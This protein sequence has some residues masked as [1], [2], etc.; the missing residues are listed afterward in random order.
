MAEVSRRAV[1]R[2]VV[3]PSSPV[4][5][6]HVLTENRQSERYA[7]RLEFLSKLCEPPIS[8]QLPFRGEGV[9]PPVAKPSR[10]F[11]PATT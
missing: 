4:V 11:A 6:K 5:P 8:A 2:L 7:V 9:L 1:S 10:G 3:K